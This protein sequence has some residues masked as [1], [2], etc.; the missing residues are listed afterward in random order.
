MMETTQHIRWHGQDVAAI[1]ETSR[2]ARSKL[3]SPFRISRMPGY[4]T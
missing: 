2:L 3:A 1:T 4:A